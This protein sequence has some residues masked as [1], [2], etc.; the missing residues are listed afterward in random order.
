M[1]ID[2]I[3][4]ALGLLSGIPVLISVQQKSVKKMLI[5]GAVG[6]LLIG[7]SYLMQGGLSSFWL[8]MIGNVNVVINLY[9]LERGKKN[10]WSITLAFIGINFI[11][12][13]LSWTGWLSLVPFVAGLCGTIACRQQKPKF[14][15]LF[16]LFNTAIWCGYDICLMA[17]TSALVH[18]SL[19]TSTAVGVFRNKDWSLS[20][21]KE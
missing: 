10:P 12:T 9:Y 4:E 11:S 14:Y 16:M 7:V 19:F 20:P 21:V 17:W 1:W 15:R 13:L 18:G 3:A 2:L 5:A 8:C 6:N